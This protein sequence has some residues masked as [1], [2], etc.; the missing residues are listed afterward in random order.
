[1]VYIIKPTF[2]KVTVTM[3]Y[4]LAKRAAAIRAVADNFPAEP[5]YI[6]IGSGSTMEHVVAAIAQ[7]PHSRAL[8]VP[9]GHQSRGLLMQARLP[10]L[11]IASLPRNARIQVAFDGAD[12]VD[13]ALN[14]IKGGGACMF[15]EKLVALQ[16]TRFVVV[17][18]P[19][20]PAR[21][22]PAPC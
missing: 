10:V 17:A 16:A 15:L 6:G 13:G 1:M 7:R 14:C 2:H 3:G 8:F 21:P 9:T 12:E 22:P 11:E 19:R 18:G 4:D 5:T 20:A